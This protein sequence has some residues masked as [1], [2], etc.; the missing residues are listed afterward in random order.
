M[1]GVFLV[2]EDKNNPVAL[3]VPTKEGVKRAFDDIS[4][5]DLACLELGNNFDEIIREYNPEYNLD[6]AYRILDT[7]ARY[8]KSLNRYCL[9]I[10]NDA[11]KELLDRFHVFAEE[12]TERINNFEGKTLS[13]CYKLDN[14][15]KYLL[16]NIY[17]LSDIEKE[18]FYNTDG[19]LP[20]PLINLLW[21]MH[22]DGEIYSGSQYFDRHQRIFRSLLSSYHY[23][24]NLT[25]MYLQVVLRQ[26]GSIRSQLDDCSKDISNQKHM[27]EEVIDANIRAYVLKSEATIRKELKKIDAQVKQ[28]QKEEELRQ[29]ELA[30]QQY[31]QMTIDDLLGNNHGVSK[32]RK[33]R[34]KDLLDDYES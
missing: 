33:G 15:I 32:V 17:R 11:S 2:N 9:N 22:N 1:S 10:D 21:V 34:V 23:L 6:G 28:M 25:T 13:N 29:M 12:R 7:N 31:H 8:K 19:L 30:N 27:P 4:M 3:N 20:Q 26:S 5:L 16:D 14:Y 18:I 24:R